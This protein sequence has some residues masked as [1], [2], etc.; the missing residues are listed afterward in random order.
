MLL[1]GPLH[2]LRCYP[3][4]GLKTGNLLGTKIVCLQIILIKGVIQGF[5]TV[6][7][8]Q[9]LVSPFGTGGNGR[10]NAA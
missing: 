6:S 4:R 8:N 10:Q 7:C 2:H 9:N 5:V 3:P 1:Q